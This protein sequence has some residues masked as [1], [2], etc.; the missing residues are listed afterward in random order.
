MSSWSLKIK[1][2]ADIIKEGS[3]FA[4]ESGLKM[5]PMTILPYLSYK[6][7]RYGKQGVIDGFD[8]VYQVTDTYADMVDATIDNF[9]E[10]PKH[11]IDDAYYTEIMEVR[12]EKLSPYTECVNTFQPYFNTRDEAKPICQRIMTKD[13]T[14][15]DL[16]WLKATEKGTIDKVRKYTPEVIGDAVS[17]TGGMISLPSLPSFP[18]LPSLPEIKLPTVGDFFSTSTKIIGAIILLIIIL[19]ALGYSGVGSIMEREHG[20]KR[21]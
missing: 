13:L 1:D 19:I 15:A 7:A 11:E 12:E 18:S 20:R 8:P 5:C 17:A 9:H 14:Q 6:Y 3:L 21:N 10:E 4:I 2:T 16:D